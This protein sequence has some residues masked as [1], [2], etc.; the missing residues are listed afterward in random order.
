MREAVYRWFAR[1]LDLP[2]DNN[3]SEPPFELEE[4]KDMLAFFDGLPDGAITQHEDL[5][6]QCIAASKTALETHRQNTPDALAENRRILGEALRIAIGYDDTTVT[7]QHNAKTQISHL[8]CEDGT[9]IGNRRKVRVPIRTFTPESPSDASTLLIHPHGMNALYTPIIHALLDKGQ[10][11][12]AIDPFGTGQNI[13]EENPEEPRGE[14]ETSS[15]PLTA[16]TMPSASATFALALRHM[17]SGPANIVG[18]GNAGL[19]AIIAS[20]ISERANLQIVSDIGAFNTTTENDYLN[21]LPIPG[22]LKAGGLPNA[23]ALI[24]PNNLLLHNT[25]DAFDTSWAEAAYALYPEA[26][27]THKK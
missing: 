4:H 19:W 1:W 18:F 17:P 3:F 26:T 6:R 2:F 15:I 11:V 8:T 24:A 27:L 23:A 7:Y 20:A 9:L 5:I 13:G 21:R 12:Y 22:I 16:P 14:R 25:G 10:T